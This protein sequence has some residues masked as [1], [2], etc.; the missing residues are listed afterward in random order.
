MMKLGVRAFG[1]FTIAVML[2]VSLASGQ[3]KRLSL[4]SAIRMAQEQSFEYKVALNRYQSSVWRFRNYNASFL[5]TLYLDGTIP[6]YSRAISRIT[7]PSGED[8]FVSQNQAYSSLNLGIRQNVALTG[9]VFSLSSS[10][11]R[12]D[13]FGSDRQV[14]Y[15]S[16]PISVSYYQQTLGYNAFKWLKETEPLRFESSDRQFVADMQRIA[17]QTVTYYFDMLAAQ[18]RLELSAQNLASTDTLYRIATDR[19]SLGTVAQSD[20]LQLRLSTLNARRQLTQDSVDAVLAHQQFSRYLLLPEAH[21]E[22]ALP[23][24]TAFFDLTF[25]QALQYAQENSQEVIDFRLQRLEAEQNLARTKA[26]NGL[27]FSLQA[28]FGLTNSARRIGGLL[29]GME[30]QQQVALGFSVPILDWG[31]ARTQRQQA[32]AD[33]AMVESQIEQQQLQLE[34]EVMLYTARWSL[35]KQQLSVATETRDI[36]AQNYELEVERFLRGAI[37]I[38]DL[39]AAQNQKDSA[40][41]GYLTALRTYWELYYTLRRLTL[42]DFENQQKL[43]FQIAAD[44]SNQ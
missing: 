28:N 36:A 21:Y 31:Y 42:F 38:N 40:A 3:G 29:Q 11:N 34:Q 9:G 16:T 13:V 8:T 5:P 26:E 20:L 19:F 17:T 39:N 15:A 35:H 23:D 30:N 32:E 41:N 33:L 27:S 14:S 44:A 2:S 7:L 18:M 22:L 24:S 1:G 4:Q 37:T 43:S 10:L 6:N 25:E 12:I